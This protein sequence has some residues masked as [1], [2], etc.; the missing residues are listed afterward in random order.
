MSWLFEFAKDQM[1]QL[2]NIINTDHWKIQLISI[3]TSD[4]YTSDHL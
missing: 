3:S 2:I 4:H 1:I